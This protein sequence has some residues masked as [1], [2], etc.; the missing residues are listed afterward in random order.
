[1]E[2]YGGQGQLVFYGA[3]RERNLWIFVEKKL[4]IPNLVFLFLKSLFEWV[5]H[6]ITI[7]AFFLMEFFDSLYLYR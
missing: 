7:S 6:S 4:S 1:M 5:T 2:L 3:F